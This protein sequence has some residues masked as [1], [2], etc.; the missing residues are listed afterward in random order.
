MSGG[1]P[2]GTT[3]SLAGAKEARRRA[4]LDAQLLANRI[5]LLKQ[6][7][8]KAWKKIQETQKRS[9]DILRLRQNNEEKYVA[10]ESFYHHKWDSIRSAQ[11]KNQAVRIKAKTT[12][13]ATRTA[14]VQHKAQE[15]R[16]MKEASQSNN[17][18]R[19][20][21]EI[22]DHQLNKERMTLIRQQ[23]DEAK[24]KQEEQQLKKLEDFRRDYETRVDHEEML[25]ART[26]ALVAK[27]EREEMDLIQRLQ[28]TQL[29]QRTAYE[30]L[31]GALG[32]T[33]Q[34]LSS[35]VRNKIGEGKDDA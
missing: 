34:A 16:A 12:R 20:E 9:K 23:R 1:M 27:M 29:A 21:R 4:E 24:R 5:A 28:N 32:T 26:E 25:R 15:A 11:Q 13:E 17:M 6:E 10:K 22:Y 14:L 7:E 31:E 2:P 35:A 3:L 19:R 30:E 8:E 33:S 18:S